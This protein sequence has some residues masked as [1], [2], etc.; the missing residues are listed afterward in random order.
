MRIL[1]FVF[2]LAL[3]T[4]G[5]WLLIRADPSHEVGPVVPCETRKVPE[6]VEPAPVRDAGPRRSAE[7][8]PEERPGPV[9]VIATTS[10]A[11]DLV[12]DVPVYLIPDTSEVASEV[13]R[14][15]SSGELAL[16]RVELS[17]GTFVARAPGWETS[18][19]R[20]ER[21]SPVR[22]LTLVLARARSVH[23]WVVDPSEMPVADALVLGWTQRS[24]SISL[25]RAHRAMSGD[26]RSLS[27]W[28]ASDGSFEIGA[29]PRDAALYFT[30]GGAGML[31][32]SPVEVPPGESPEV[33]I[34]VAPV[35]A[36]LARF[37]DL[38]G[39]PAAIP[40]GWIRGDA[41]LRFEGAL[42]P[43]TGPRSA[44][45]AAG[46]P[47]NLLASASTSERLYYGL[48]FDGALEAGPLTVDPIEFPGYEPLS[49]ST[50][51]YRLDQGLRGVD[52]R[53]VPTVEQR[54]S[55]RL[56]IVGPAGTTRS[57]PISGASAAT[58]QM[59]PS[60][61]PPLTLGV[62]DLS[63][64]EKILDGIPFGTYTAV[65]A[66]AGGMW[67]HPDAGLGGK[68]LVIGP[69][70]AVWRIDLSHL[71]TLELALRDSSGRPYAG[72][73]SAVLVRGD[74]N[75]GDYGVADAIDIE[76]PPYSIA[77]LPAGEY[78]IQFF[79]PR[80]D[81]PAASFPVVHLQPGEVSRV[82]FTVR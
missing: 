11:G 38:D 2:L 9:L 44:L 13:G 61:G 24:R 33:R 39:R 37:V 66:T 69:T 17:D 45:L 23:G 75:R 34:V 26:P 48:A 74:L 82:P 35:Y 16:D 43:Y 8:T 72:R 79:E 64:G 12:P 57:A 49:F 5:A 29:L 47:E 42:R 41:A 50:M 67:V 10:T 56:V 25:R 73:L 36:V 78:S 60:S 7:P 40:S 27:A 54:G 1:G 58:V 46:V 31:A 32:A 81:G 65:L 63:P 52:V 53:L 59:T 15:D 18:E 77:G 51:L 55:L 6:A 22:R 71:S 68:D 14:T 4:L 19:A 70:E 3:M 21:A 76:E 30:A 80:L 62:R 20:Y 28:T